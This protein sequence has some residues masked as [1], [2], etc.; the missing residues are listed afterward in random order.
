MGTKTVMSMVLGI[1]VENITAK[2]TKK[3]STLVVFLTFLGDNNKKE[4]L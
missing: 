1:C 2:R 3:L 4:G